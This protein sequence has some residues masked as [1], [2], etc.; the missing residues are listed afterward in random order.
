ML[1]AGRLAFTNLVLPV[2]LSS[3]LQLLELGFPRLFPFQGAALYW[4]HH[5][6]ADCRM[7][8][9]DRRGP[10]A[11]AQ[12][13]DQSETSMERD[14]SPCRRLQRDP[15]F[16]DPQCESCFSRLEEVL[17]NTVYAGWLIPPPRIPTN[18]RIG[19]MLSGG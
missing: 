3:F 7:T 10:W 4:G 15:R 9:L 12:P 17:R 2:K 11:M 8:D 18:R 16:D 5:R 14:H 6:F 13:S 1:P 19:A